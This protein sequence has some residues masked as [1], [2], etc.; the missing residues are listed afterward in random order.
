MKKT[1]Y[2][3]IALMFAAAGSKAQT[4]CHA[5]F[6]YHASGLTVSFTDASTSSNSI[7]SWL[8]NFGDSQTSTSQ[9]P[10][11]TYAAAGTYNVCLTITDNHGCHS[12]TCHDV[13]VG[14][15]HPCQASFTFTTD[16]TGM[17]YYFTNTS[18]GTTSS[19][20]YTWDFGDNTTS[21]ME[22]PTHTYVHAGNSLVCL[23]M[24]DV[25]TGCHSHYCHHIIHNP[26]HHHHPHHNPHKEFHSSEISEENFI[27]YPNPVAGELNI[28][29]Y[30]A[31]DETSVIR[32]SDVTGKIIYA[33][34]FKLQTGNNN[35]SIPVKVM[36]IESGIYFLSV[37]HNN[38]IT[39]RKVIIN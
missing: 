19:T 26:V 20:V 39:T 28:S 29:I 27:V 13:T 8:W 14:V 37:N 12:T 17:T 16:S 23:Y 1:I 35:F 3:I 7:A 9:N 38:N 10:T 22:S 24:S 6:T 32:L 25:S 4:T 30:N 21:N 11:H 15:L 31:S 36:K 18:T 34:Q 33:Q 5:S 2:I